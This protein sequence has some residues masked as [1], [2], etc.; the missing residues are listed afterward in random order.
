MKYTENIN[1]PLFH[2]SLLFRKCALCIQRYIIACN[3]KE[4]TVNRAVKAKL[5]KTD[6]S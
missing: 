2:V 6:L 3:L 1:A 5:V 4:L